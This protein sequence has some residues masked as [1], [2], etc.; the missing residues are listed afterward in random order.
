MTV[1][2]LVVVVKGMGRNM[3]VREAPPSPKEVVLEWIIGRVRVDPG[4]LHP[5]LEGCEGGEAG[6]SEQHGEVTWV[7]LCLRKEV[8]VHL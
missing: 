1:F 7:F 2:V 5:C 3:K 6:Q 8:R 4:I